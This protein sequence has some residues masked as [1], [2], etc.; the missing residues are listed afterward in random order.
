MKKLYFL[1]LFC[2]S[3]F[4]S[5]ELVYPASQPCLKSKKVCYQI[6][7]C[8]YRDGARNN[9]FRCIKPNHYGFHLYPHQIDR[10]TCSL[11][12]VHYFQTMGY[13]CF[14]PRG[15]QACIKKKVTKKCDLQCVK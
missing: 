12:A 3:V 2:F 1:L 6:E 7:E 9:C 4:A 8:I 10:N 14:Q 13:R 5:P 11:Q 15:V